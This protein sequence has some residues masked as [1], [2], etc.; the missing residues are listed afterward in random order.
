MGGPLFGMHGRR[1]MAVA[2]ASNMTT[3]EGRCCLRVREVSFFLF[4]T[5]VDLHQLEPTHIESGRLALIRAESGRIGRNR[6]RVRPRIQ[7]IQAKFKLKK[8]RCET[9]C[10]KSSLKP[11]SLTQKIHSSPLYSQSL[12]SLLSLRLPILTL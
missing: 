5:C 2:V 10:F 12:S 8:K 4:L 1:K 11:N 7:P 6:F 3:C 9:H